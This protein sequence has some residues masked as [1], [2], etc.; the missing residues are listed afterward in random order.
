MHQYTPLAIGIQSLDSH[1]FQEKKVVRYFLGGIPS[2]KN[3]KE[4]RYLFGKNGR[5]LLANPILGI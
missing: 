3:H 2:R 4:W 1:V 5:I